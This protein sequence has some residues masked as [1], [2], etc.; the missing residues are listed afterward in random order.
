VRQDE[1]SAEGGKNMAADGLYVASTIKNDD[2]EIFHTL[3]RVPVKFELDDG[4][5]RTCVYAC[6]C[7]CACMRVRGRAPEP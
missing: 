4:K 2:P 3:S 6:V 7:L 1:Q 5:V